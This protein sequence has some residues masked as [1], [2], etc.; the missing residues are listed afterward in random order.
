MSVFLVLYM[1]EIF[2]IKND[3]P[4]ITGNK[5]FTV[6]IV[7][8][9]DFEKASLILEIYRDRSKRLIEFSQSNIHRMFMSRI[10]S[11]MYIMYEIEYGILTRIVSGYLQDPDK[12]NW[13]VILKYLETTKDR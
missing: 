12:N 6:I 1:N 11:I 10:Y 8:H 4:Y 7:L 3:I 5:S 13:K 2:L 9:K